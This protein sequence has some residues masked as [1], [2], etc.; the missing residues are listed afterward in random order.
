EARLVKAADKLDLLLQAFEYEK[1]GARRLQEFW[2]SAE[3]DFAG[4]GVDGLIEDLVTALKK[5]R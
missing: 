5:L 3:E 4:L 1:G 2:E